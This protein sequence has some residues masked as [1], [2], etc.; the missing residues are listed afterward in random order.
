MIVA[1]ACLNAGHP[2]RA[3]RHCATAREPNTNILLEAQIEK[4]L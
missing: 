4:G 2:G 3:F 1:V